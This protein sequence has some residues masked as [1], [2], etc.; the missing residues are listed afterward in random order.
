MNKKHTKEFMKSLPL[1]NS[2]P[3][4][5]GLDFKRALAP[6]KLVWVEIGED[7]I[8]VWKSLLCFHKILRIS[9]TC[10]SSEP[11]SVSK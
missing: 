8:R 10:S 9:A 5:I 2:N 1:K 3:F 7:Q 4:I 11:F 6:F